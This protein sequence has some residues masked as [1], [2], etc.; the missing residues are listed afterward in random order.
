MK[1]NSL[2]VAICATL[3]VAACS[4]G[5]AGGGGAL[6]GAV[7]GFLDAI[8]AIIGTTSEIIEAVSIDAI[9]LATSETAEASAFAFF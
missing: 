9:T 7:S 3:L 2:A 5:D 4:G 1:Q 6:G 8:V